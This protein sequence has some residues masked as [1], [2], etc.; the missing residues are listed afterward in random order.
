MCP[1]E[2]QSQHPALLQQAQLSALLLLPE[3]HLSQ[4]LVAVEFPV[5][6]IQA[7]IYYHFAPG[8]CYFC[9]ANLVQSVVVV[10]TFQ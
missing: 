1:M 7:Q 3:D 2:E 5:R 8:F 4:T 6:E 9:N 10:F